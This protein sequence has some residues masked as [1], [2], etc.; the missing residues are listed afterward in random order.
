MR[1]T[2]KPQTT[3]SPENF[4]QESGLI[5]TTNIIGSMT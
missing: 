1:T 4:G 2:H 5:V 3:K